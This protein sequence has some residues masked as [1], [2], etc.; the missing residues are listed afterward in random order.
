MDKIKI[1]D[2]TIR[3]AHQSLIATRLKTEEILPILEK[4]DKVGYESLE[5]WGGATFDVCIR[6]L[7]EDPWQ[8]LREIRKIV[9]NSKLQMLL[10]GQNLLG[11]RH[12]ADDLVDKF[13]EKSIENGI[14]V[15]RIFDALNDY[16]NLET[17]CKATKNYGAHAQLAMSY[18]I[19]PV[20]TDEYYLDLAQKFYE[21]GADSICIK[22][23]SGILIPDRANTLITKIKENIDLPLELHSHSTAGLAATTYLAAV[24]AGVDIIDTAIS[25][26]A[27]GT[28]QPPVE[29]FLKILENNPRKP[30]FDIKLLNEIAE[31]FKVIRDRHVK[32]GSLNPKALFINPTIIDSQV[33][34][35][36]LSNL[37]SQLKNQNAEDKYDMVLEE[38]RKVR[39]DLGY[40]PLVTPISQMVGTQAVFNVLKNER[41]SMV[42]HEIH[43]YVSGKYGKSPSPIK[44]DILKKIIGD[45]KILESRPADLLED[46]FDKLKNEIGALAK[47]DEDVLTYALFPQIGKRFLENREKENSIEVHNINVLWD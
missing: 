4:I 12:Y 21:M 3:D 38:V 18:T 35:G 19:S 27:G 36:M 30:D 44:E 7:N 6:F 37:I 2:T 45:G 1:M 26:F 5:V 47:S 9:K 40:P 15:I 28:S 10:R 43:D 33:P 34:G 46:E 16:R 20:H 39:E 13:I 8:R 23:M 24:N 42:P 14:D 41:Y 22:D 17:A 25:P 11:Y 32:E 31:Y 29:S